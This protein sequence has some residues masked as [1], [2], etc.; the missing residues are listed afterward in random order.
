MKAPKQW[1]KNKGFHSLQN[2]LIQSRKICRRPGNTYHSTC[3]ETIYRASLIL[4][5]NTKTILFWF[6]PFARKSCK[7]RTLSSM[8]LL[9]ISLSRI[10]QVILTA[11]AR[12]HSTHHK[13][14]KT[15]ALSSLTSSASFLSGTILGQKREPLLAIT[16]SSRHLSCLRLMEATR[17]TRKRTFSKAMT[18]KSLISARKG[19]SFSSAFSMSSQIPQM[20]AHGIKTLTESMR[21]RNMTKMTIKSITSST[22]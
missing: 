10:L 19:T 6:S 17:T 9:T 20:A 2:I 12:E 4:M 15:E 5:E 22:N 21:F 3:L 16:L 18:T 1:N 11:Y 14:K 8:V 7:I 13:R